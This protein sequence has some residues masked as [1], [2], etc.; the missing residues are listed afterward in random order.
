MS[1]IIQVGTSWRASVRLAGHKP[2]HQTFSKKGD[3]KKWADE[4]EHKLRNPDNKT[5]ETYTVNEVIDAYERIRLSADREITKTSNTGFELRHLREGFGLKKAGRL[6]TTEI[7]L[8]VQDGIAKMRGR[9]ALARE[10]TLL[11]T[12]YRNGA[13]ILGIKLE[14]SELDNAIILLSKMGVIQVASRY[15]KRVI[16]DTELQNILDWLDG[17]VLDTSMQIINGNPKVADCVRIAYILGLRQS[18][19]LNLKWADLDQQTKMIWVRSRK[20]PRPDKQKQNDDH[21]PLILGSF[22]VIMVQPQTHE[23]I[24]PNL[25]GENV[26][27]WFLR[28]CRANRIDDLHFHDLRHSAI[29]NLFRRG[30]KIERVALISGHKDWRS[31]RRYTNLDPSDLHDLVKEYD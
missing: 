9:Y 10:L 8:W 21:V 14:T 28:A 1:S 3:A 12:C 20:H 2:Q 13:A 4:T 30:L 18:E 19:I 27:D 26:S 6:T 23:K 11:K 16:S 24:F 15:R 25:R 31:L 7:I 22:E 5:N 17:R 29:T